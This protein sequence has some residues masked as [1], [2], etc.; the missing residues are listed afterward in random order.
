[1]C[2]CREC[3][4]ELKEAVSSLIFATSRCGGFPELQQIRE[5]FVSRFG[6]EFA[7]RAAELQNNCGVN[8]K[9][10]I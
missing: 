6:K 7:A 10:R 3:P 4:D 1:M 5:M 2:L 9:A 8:L